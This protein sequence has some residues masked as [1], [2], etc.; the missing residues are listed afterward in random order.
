MSR[1]PRRAAAAVL[2]LSLA[3]LTAPGREPEVAPAPRIAL[4]PLADSLKAIPLRPIGPCLTPGRVGDIAVDPKNRSIWYVAIASGGL[5]KTTNRGTTW[6]PI[7][8]N[9][10]S[11]SMGCVTVDPKNTDVVWLGTGENQSQRSVGFG[12][13]VYK[14]T[15]GGATWANVGLKQSEH[16]AKI[17]LDPR[18][19]AV[20]Y[21]AAQ[22]P[23][24]APGG[25]RG[26]YKSSDGGKTWKA[27][28]TAGE[29]TGV[30][31]VC[32]DTKNPDVLYAATYQRR[33]NVGVVIGGG[34]EAG[35][36]KSEDAGK[37][38][39]K[40]TKG[41][42]ETNLGRIALAVSPQKPEVVYAHVQ[43]AVAG[44]GFYRSDD[45]GATWTK[46]AALAVQD[47]QYYGEIF[48]DPAKFDRV[49]VMDMVIRIT[50]D[51]GK[52][53]RTP[54]WTMHPDN[55][56]IAFDP[57]DAN[58]LIVGNDGGLYETQDNGKTW[59][60][61]DTLSTTQFY[62]IAV[63]DAVPFYNVYGGS[64]DNGTMA[65]PVRG[66]NRIGVRTSDWGSV[67]GAD[68]MQPRI[69]P[70][71]PDVVYTMSQGG[72][73]L[74]LDKQLGRS[75]GIRP[76]AGGKAAVR[77]N[78]DTAFII[79][80]HAPKRLY[81]AGNRVFRSDD[82]GDNWKAISPDL[83]RQLD[84]LKVEVMGKVWGAD[85][86]SRNTF[87]TPLSIINALS[88]SPKK[89]GLLY[90]G[91]DD[92]LVQVT[93]D[94]GGNWVKVE[95][96][97]GVPAGTYVS[98]LFAS[99]HDAST[100][101][102]AFNNYLRGDF[103]PYILKSADRGKTWTDASGN[104]PNRQPVWCVVEDAVNK[105][106][107]FA[108]TEF[109]LFVTLDGGTTWTRYPGSPVIPFRD[110]EVQA[111][112]GDL[113]CGTF[114]RGILVIDDY[115]PLRGMT[116]DARV[117]DAMLF[118][119]RKTR[120]YAELPYARAGNEFVAPNPPPG[121]LF[122]YHLRESLGDAK[123]TVKV[124]D[125]DGKTLREVPASGSAGLHRVNWDLRAGGVGPR[126]GDVVKPG[127]YTAQLMK[128]VG[129]DDPVAVGG[130]QRFEVIPLDGTGAAATAN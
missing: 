32:F 51:G 7:F 87:T 85:A 55:H 100:V 42:P 126:G 41:L 64:Q 123:L 46:G 75:T 52:T 45:G 128:A 8:D 86:V 21:V 124:T 114:G 62:R 2:L 76:Q 63:D 129:K 20:V 56:A 101:Y 3:A 19:S 6:T 102:A 109:G 29:D 24:W 104:L 95:S 17:L 58:H 61:F 31:D 9:Q 30:T 48:C 117:R 84:P 106:L 118:P 81:F 97:P 65:G 103:K 122:T 15:D 47:G 18:D 40:L 115:A 94:G 121:A 34:P 108:G 77:Y 92:G 98:D 67:G 70:G 89:E 83:T 11:Y 4:P 80:P 27:V 69:E 50:E 127:R 93:D 130:A 91:T 110:L 66:R 14:S 96:F 38:W 37:S 119:V 23:L 33:R 60:H 53:F 111:R 71:N 25:D 72:A 49:Y 57:T 112:E 78:W 59:R 105:N 116:P 125:A 44:P 13:G 113:V 88:E 99:N 120:A 10:G 36:F 35:V 68:G 5:W 12:D 79:S 28:L 26:L 16:V 73:L 43:T 82:R 39:K 1:H 90:A 107:L 54:N 74:R 22:G